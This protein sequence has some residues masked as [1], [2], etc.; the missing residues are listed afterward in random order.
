VDA[1][2]VEYGD[3]RIPPSIFSMKAFPL[4]EQRVAVT[5]ENITA[6][7]RARRALQESE[8]RFRGAFHSSSVGMALTSLDGSFVQVNERL[9]EML[10]YSTEELMRIGVAGISEP[11]DLEVDRELA[12]EMIAGTRDSFQREKRYVRKDGSSV[13][14]ELTSSVVRTYDGAATHVVSHVQDITERMEANMLFAATFERSVVPML[15]ADDD[16]R[17]VDINNAGVQLIGVEYDEAV[18]LAIDDLLPDA[19]VPADWAAFRAEGTL[20][21]EVTMRRPDGVRRRIEFTATAD[22]RPGRHIA[23]VR[24]LSHQKE[25]EAQLRQAQKMEA[26]GRLAGGIAHDFNN[27]LTAITGYSEF[28]VSGLDDP[29]LRR[30]A[31]EIT[32]AS[33]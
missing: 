20:A 9:G 33:S 31:E 21:A 12:A 4:S 16:R 17:I 23:V 1:G 28:L 26:V 18:G 3:E 22:I 27:L 30:H 11:A 2:E 15:I 25:L 19:P 5:F 8:S 7:V 29:R 10:G 14:G 6:T 24:D 32:K 13:W